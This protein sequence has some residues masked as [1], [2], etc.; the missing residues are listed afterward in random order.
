MTTSL[1]DTPYGVAGSDHRLFKG[2]AD[3]EERVESL[4]CRR[5]HAAGRLFAGTNRDRKDMFITHSRP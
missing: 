1:V 3:L 5:G 4:R 2:V